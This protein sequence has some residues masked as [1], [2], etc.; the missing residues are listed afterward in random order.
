MNE[1]YTQTEQ[2]R[3][4]WYRYDP[5]RDIWYPI[6]ANEGPISRWA[7]LMLVVILA[8]AAYCIEYRPGIV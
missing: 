5:D 1:L 4:R 6:E 7:W 2:I 3:G 8:I